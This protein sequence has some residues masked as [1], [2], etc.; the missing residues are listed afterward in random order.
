MTKPTIPKLDFP[1]KFFWGAS[2]A[3]HQVEGGTHN[4]WSIWE[5]E[6]AAT[7]AQQAKYEFTHL[8]VWEEIKDEA[9]NPKNYISGAACNHYN[10]YEEDFDRLTQL[11]MNAFRFSIEWSRIEPEEGRWDNHAIEHYKLYLHALQR[12]GIEPFVTLWH[13]TMPEWFTAKGGFEKRGNVKYFVRFAQKVC[14]EL[15]AEFRYLIT[16]NEPEVYMYHSYLNANWPPMKDSKKTALCVYFNLI[17]AHKK[18]YQVAKNINR[19]FIV[20][21]TMNIPHDYA[22]DDAWLTQKTA[23]FRQ[24]VS[25]FFTRRIRKHLD[26]IGLNYYFTNRYYGSR[27]HNP[28]EKV[29]DLGWDMQPQDIEFVLERLH[30][31]FGLP[32]II[33]ENGVADRGDRYRKWWISETVVAMQRALDKGVKLEGY[34]HWSLLDNFEW[35]YGFWPRFGLIEVDYKTQQRTI[36]PSAKWFGQVIKK[37]R[38]G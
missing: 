21:A 4:Q 7:R 20:G 18:V 15:G 8:P 30:K 34:L 11:N 28:D 22:G 24:Y 12:R 17:N 6:N 16:L 9:I 36:R 25:H 31:E 23:K 27:V 35:A 33:T 29:S 14:H 13:W 38:N 2:T 3:A 19:K 26:F 37:L 1:K 10:L 32:I 5:L